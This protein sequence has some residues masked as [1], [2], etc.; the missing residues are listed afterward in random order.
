MPQHHTQRRPK[1]HPQA[2]CNQPPRWDARWFWKYFTW[3]NLSISSTWPKCL[4]RPCSSPIR[5][6]NRES[7]DD[8][9]V[10]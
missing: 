1:V 7:T 8:P 4:R 10:T 6:E 5:M 2:L 9:M 3:S